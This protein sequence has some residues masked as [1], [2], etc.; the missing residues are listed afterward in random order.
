VQNQTALPAGAAPHAGSTA[1]PPA[2][3]PITWVPTLYFAQGVPY[4][5][6]MAIAALLFKDL[7]IENSAIT[8]WT[9]A[10]GL[11]WVVKPLWS[12]FLEA[13][14]SKKLL[15]VVF[16][17][18]GAATLGLVALA[19]NVPHSVSLV[20]VILGFTAFA[21]ATH[22]ISS[23]GLY[24]ASL[25][26]RLQAEYAG[27]QGAFFNA[28]RLFARG[29]VLVLVGYL[30]KSMEAAHAWSAVF[31]LLAVVMGT[32]AAYHLW[33]L[34]D[35]RV[36]AD[37]TRK[38]ADIAETTAE[39]VIEFF[40]KPGIW[41]AILFIILFR[42]GEG[43]IQ[44]VGPLFLRDARTVGG[45]GLSTDQIGVV[46]GT[47]ATVAFVGGSI[48]GGYFTSWLGLRRSMVWL[49]IAMN[50]PN[51]VYWWLSTA[52]PTDMSLI[53][54]GLSIE[55][56]GYGFGFVGIILFIMQVVAKGRFTTAH[57]ALGTGVM[58]LGFILS[59]TWSGEIQT[60]LGYQHFF[61]W[62]L[63]CALPVLVLSFFLPHNRDEPAASA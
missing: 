12:P 37:A 40:K 22:D 55:M 45:L 6:V 63:A 5:V 28:A 31:V 53:A 49:V 4:F 11:A 21:S 17:L 1:A 58:Q 44:S 27:W 10:L 24:I 7:G 41:F 26:D 8:R 35:T 13:V 52:R 47:W 19:L 23:D 57:Y 33:A 29:G 25:S 3:S 50:L 16:Q 20:L 62:V 2:R 14:P 42:A 18:I 38:V 60:W 56:F 46:Y 34:P 43:Q 32:L 9:N 59:G 61:L 54:T 48:V 15:V 36:G 30:E 39:V 51:L